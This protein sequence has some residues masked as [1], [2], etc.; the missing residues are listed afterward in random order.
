M[1]TGGFVPL[2]NLESDVKVFPEE[3]KAIG[4]AMKREIEAMNMKSNGAYVSL[5]SHNKVMEALKAAE[6][7]LAHSKPIV[8]QSVESVTRHTEALEKVK[9]A[10]TGLL[11][12]DALGE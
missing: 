7:A 1:L 4:E 8:H 3:A 12:D 11:L 2:P 5:D 6:M 9:D 10:Q